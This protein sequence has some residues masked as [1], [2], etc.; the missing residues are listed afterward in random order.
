MYFFIS[1]I[2]VWHQIYV[3]IV[4]NTF[5]FSVKGERRSLAEGQVEVLE[6]FWIGENAL[7]REWKNVLVREWGRILG[8]YEVSQLVSVV[9]P[10]LT[11]CDPMDC[12]PLGSSVHGMFLSR[13]QEWVAISSSR[14]SFHARDQTCISHASC[15][16]GRFFT[17]QPP[18]KPKYVI[19]N[20]YI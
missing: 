12:C 20:S 19:I 15:I 11:L 7:K 9:Q 3:L 5:G 13:I 17:T 10:C 1:T 18:G 2:S 14:R 16:T 6:I 4:V 8:P